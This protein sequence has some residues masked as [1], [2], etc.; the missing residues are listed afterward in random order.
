MERN[1]PHNIVWFMKISP[2]PKTSV[3]P[4][5]WQMSQ[6]TVPLMEA[7]N[8]MANQIKSLCPTLKPRAQ[9]KEDPANLNQM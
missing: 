9:N 8:K 4:S 7:K 5:S 6:V 2:R 1:N 3:T